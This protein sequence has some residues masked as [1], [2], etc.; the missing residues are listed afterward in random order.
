MQGQLTIRLSGTLEQ[1]LEALSTRFHQR[2]SEIVRNALERFIAEETIKDDP[3]PW[4]KIQHL[5]GAI[6]TGVTDL[7]E[8]HEEHLRS[9]FKRN[10]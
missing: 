2:K 5:A 7:G 10:G 3:S 1:G 8:A 6:E 9:R 4:Q